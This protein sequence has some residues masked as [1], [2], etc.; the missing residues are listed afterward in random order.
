MRGIR[1]SIRCER[2]RLKSL[3]KRKTAYNKHNMKRCLLFING[4]IIHSWRLG[5]KKQKAEIEVEIVIESEIENRNE[6]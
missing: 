5:R 2:G 6:N 3:E 1:V 4:L